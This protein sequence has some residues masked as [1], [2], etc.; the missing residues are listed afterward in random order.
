MSKNQVNAV[1]SFVRNLKEYPFTGRM[2][3]AQKKELTD[4]IKAEFIKDN[5]D[6][7]FI[8]LA[9]A[10]RLKCLALT[11]KGLMDEGF[12]GSAV[13]VNNERT[14]AILINGEDHLQINCIDTDI[15][16]AY[17]KAK[18][19]EKKLASLYG[20]AYSEKLGYLTASPV[21][22][23]TGMHGSITMHLPGITHTRMLSSLVRHIENLGLTI[24]NQGNL[25]RI[26]NRV[27]LGVAENDIL[28]RLTK[29]AAHIEKQEDKLIA[30][31]RKSQGIALE[32][33]IFRAVGVMS[34]ARLISSD[35]MSSVYNLCR[36]GIE[37]GLIDKDLTALDKLYAACRPATLS[38]NDNADTVTLREK[39]RAEKCREFMN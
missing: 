3:D 19:L 22:L 39:L 12:R 36:T 18:E 7:E 1:V 34:N 26:S 31:I 21:N 37:L 17:E 27:T 29:V 5:S 13:I 16:K 11:E 23:G 30:D 15:N 35:E 9:N 10:D 38:I 2:T 25:F 4:K 14:V 28:E 6:Y 32:D 24:D 8:D 33:R 20:F